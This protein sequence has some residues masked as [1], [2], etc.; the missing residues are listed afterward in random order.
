MPLNTGLSS[1]AEEFQNGIQTTLEGIQ[2]TINISDDISVHGCPHAEHDDNLRQVVE[3]KLFTLNRQECV[4]NKINISY[5]GDVWSPKGISADHNML[6]AIRKIN[7][8]QIA[9]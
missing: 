8:P 2:K 3:G 1:A 9:Q 5:F 7:T 6:E 4:F